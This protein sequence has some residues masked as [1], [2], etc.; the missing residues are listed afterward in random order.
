MGVVT[1]QSHWH[2]ISHILVYGKNIH[3]VPIVCAAVGSMSIELVII[4]AVHFEGLQVMCILM[5][6]ADQV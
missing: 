2:F 6:C 1:K 5:Q 4:E 3:L